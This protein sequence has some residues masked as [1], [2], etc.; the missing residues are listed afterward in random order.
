MQPGREGKQTGKLGSGVRGQGMQGRALACDLAR[1]WHRAL[2]PGSP[3]MGPSFQ[4]QASVTFPAPRTWACSW[5]PPYR[6]LSR[7]EAHKNRASRPNH[8]VVQLTVDV[9]YVFLVS[10]SLLPGAFMAPIL[11]WASVQPRGWGWGRQGCCLG[12][13]SLPR[14]PHHTDFLSCGPRGFLFSPLSEQ[15]PHF[16]CNILQQVS[17]LL[18]LSEAQTG[19]DLAESLRVW[20]KVCHGRNSGSAGRPGHVQGEP[21]EGKAPFSRT[22]L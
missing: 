1:L 18:L 8:S 4:E 10:G 14:P 9:T 19:W 21:M 5:I 2:V 11:C 16:F 6:H 13:T 15:L 3:E 17:G 20:S 22:G 7:A 12:P